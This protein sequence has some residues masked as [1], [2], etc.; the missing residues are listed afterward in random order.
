MIVF[1]GL[2]SVQAPNSSNKCVNYASSMKDLE[3][4]ERKNERRGI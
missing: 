1:S 4:A 2:A 3:S